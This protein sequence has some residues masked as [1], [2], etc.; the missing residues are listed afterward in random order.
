MNILKQHKWIVA[1]VAV[2]A[3]IYIGGVVHYQNHF[4]P[5]TTVLGTNIAGQDV[6]KANST[7]NDSLKTANYQFKENGKTILT[8]SQSK[9]GVQSNFSKSLKTI[10]SDQNAWS[11]P[12]SFISGGTTKIPNAKALLSESDLANFS[13]TTAAKL[14]KN[15]KA[16]KDADLSFKNGKL[17][18][19]KQYQG[20]Q[21]D[22]DKLTEAIKSSVNDNSNTIDISKTYG[23]PQLTTSSAKFKT[24]KAK[25]TKIS[26]VSGTLKIYNNKQADLSKSKIQSWV[27]VK[28]GQVDLDEHKVRVYLDTLTD[29]Y[30]TYGKNHKFN[31]TSSGTIEVNGGL[32]G[33]SVNKDKEY[34]DLKNSIMAGKSFNKWIETKGS[35]YHKD[36]TDIGSTYVEVSI[37][38]QHEY[39][40]QDGKLVCDSD[41]VTGNPNTGHGTPTGV[42]SVWSK[43]RDATL[44]GQNDNGSDYAQPVSYWMPI[45]DTGVGLHDSSWQPKYGGDWYETHGSHGCVNNPPSFMATLF[46]DV[47]VGTPVVVY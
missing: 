6:K 23:K 20:N 34:A 13:A 30:G 15:R 17:V 3:V 10:A 45:D 18:V 35:G 12:I 43:Q 19:S 7:L 14:N 42:Y 2:I 47:S 8:A 36:G 37:S 40:Y 41:V 46:N 24:L 31:S 44:K 25:M 28:D 1:I 22:S 9:I 38:G 32:Y 33:W 4:L 26:N 16:S 27:S 39:Y 11:W 29:K 5:K 21:I